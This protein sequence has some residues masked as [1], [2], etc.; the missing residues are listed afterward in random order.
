MSCTIGNVAITKTQHGFTLCEMLIALSIAALI[1]VFASEAVIQFNR[2]AKRIHELI[3]HQSTVRAVFGLILQYSQS[4]NS[5]GVTNLHVGSSYPLVT[6]H[7]F[8]LGDYLGD[9]N[10][11][12]NRS[13]LNDQALI[14]NAF[15]VVDATTQQFNCR[16]NGTSAN[17]V[18]FVAAFNAEGFDGHHWV[19]TI[20]NPQHI[21]LFVDT[22]VASESITI[23]ILP[24]GSSD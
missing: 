12:G 14:V 24:Y 3:A 4:V 10:C 2:T 19:A 18:D 20:Q 6:F 9:A 17:L 15:A 7:T 11:L 21:R 1:M 16:S 13:M 23:A 22:P 8:R 5:S